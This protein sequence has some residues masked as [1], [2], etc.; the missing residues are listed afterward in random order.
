MTI[1]DLAALFWPKTPYCPK[2]RAEARRAIEDEESF[3]RFIMGDSLGLRHFPSD[4]Y[5]EDVKEVD[6]RYKPYLDGG[7]FVGGQVWPF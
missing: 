5:R 7:Y 3:F 1:L 6:E 2:H 4:A